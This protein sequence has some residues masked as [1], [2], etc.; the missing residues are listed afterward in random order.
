MSLTAMAAIGAIVM[1]AAEGAASVLGRDLAVSAKTK[2]AS[3]DAANIRVSSGS[4]DF[5][6]SLSGQQL[7]SFKGFVS[8]PQFESL[9][10]QAM[11]SAIVNRRQ[12]D[13]STLRNQIRH[14][15][16]HRGDFNGPDLLQA[17]DAVAD[18]IYAGVEATKRRAATGSLDS[19]RALTMAALS[20]AAAARNSELLS[21]IE[22]LAE[23]E[24]FAEALRSAMRANTNKLRLA[25]SVQNMRVRHGQLYVPPKLQ[26]SKPLTVRGD[27][28]RPS[29][30]VPS[31]T[32]SKG[33]KLTISSLPADSTRH[34]ILG[35]PGAG[36]STLATKF[37]HDLVTD[38]IPGMEGQVPILLI[39]R[40][41]TQSLRTD[42]QTLVHYLEASCRRPHNLNP[43]K[44][45]LD[46]LLLNGRATVVIDGVDEL[47]DA[48]FRES[49]AEL[50]DNF[51]RLYPLTR[52]VVTSRVVG[53]TEAPL[54]YE[55]FPV[56][57]ILPFD[58]TQVSAYASKWFKLDSALT[59]D[60]QYQLATSFM[61]ES[62]AAGDLRTNPLLLSLLCSLYSSVHFIPKNKPEIFE[63]CAELLFETWDRSRGIETSRR[64][65]AHIKPA[66]QRLAW[67]ILTDEKGRQALPRHEIISFLA[68]FMQAK[69]FEDIDEATQAAKDFLD[70]CAGRAW[71]LTDMGAD[72]LQPH[73]GFVHR[74]FLEYFAATQL[75]KTDPTPTSVWAQLSKNVGEPSWEVV[76]QL[77]VQLIDRQV[78]DGAERILNLL[79][80][81]VDD[82]FTPTARKALLLAFGVRVLDVVAPD[83][84]TLRSLTAHCVELA[85][86]VPVERR[87][88]NLSNDKHWLETARISGYGSREVMDAPLEALLELSSTDNASRVARNMVETLDTLANSSPRDPSGILRAVLT[89]GPLHLIMQPGS[90]VAS[91]VRTILRERPTPASAEYWF[92]LQKAPSQEDVREHGTRILYERIVF[93]NGLLPSITITA[94]VAIDRTVAEQTRLEAS[95]V[96]DCLDDIF[97]EVFRRRHELLERQ[98]ITE[99]VYVDRMARTSV[100]DL[101]SLP[102]NARACLLLLL[103]P[104]MPSS[105]SDAVDSSL[106]QIFWARTFPYRRQD[107]VK[108]LNELQ[109]PAEAHAFMVSWIRGEN[110]ISRIAESEGGVA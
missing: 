49:F 46:Y 106:M 10:Q 3:Q 44:S 35:D 100:S 83:N 66:I 74:T 101:K 6:D 71:V 52:I 29:G 2:R 42:H 84:A 43:P 85:C 79:L 53:Y 99:D 45:A 91:D 76:A 102:V 59:R 37:V 110:L 56:V 64:Y 89:E 38:N 25:H 73:Y 105:P 62:A 90:S 5:V 57:E 98:P 13:E 7:Q 94:L 28:L 108:L 16:R 92:R 1:K 12:T 68:A 39:V 63:R 9:V 41:H 60:E 109:L 15:L 19:G 20:A 86:S 104:V 82:P 32:P 33:E 40:N 24:K 97:F 107:A 95:P 11:I 96:I 87:R 27:A 36:K 61:D 14:G 72:T 22:S 65:G 103:I 58:D 23:V 4:A 70:F 47:G 26:R 51:A 55:L 75:V 17:T 50:V 93:T 81:E 21:R 80:K 8:S 18:L 67:L 30:K 77:A 88:P 34:V 31:K 54:D 48:S 69:R 78:D